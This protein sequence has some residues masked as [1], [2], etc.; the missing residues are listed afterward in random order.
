MGYL[1]QAAEEIRIG[2]RDF[3]VAARL[4]GLLA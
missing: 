3:G 4:I 2:L 1:G